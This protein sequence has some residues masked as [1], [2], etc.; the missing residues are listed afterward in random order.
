[1]GLLQLDLFTHIV[2]DDKPEFLYLSRVSVDPVNAFSVDSVGRFDGADASSH[3]KRDAV[4]DALTAHHLLQLSPEYLTR[5][6]K[7]IA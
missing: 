2:V 7:G 5:L 4:T 3:E 6:G 1:M